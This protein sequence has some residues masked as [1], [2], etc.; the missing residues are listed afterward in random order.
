MPDKPGRLAELEARNAELEAELALYRDAVEHM[1]EGLCVFDAQ[2]RIALSNRRYEEVLRLPKGSVQPGLSSTELIQLGIDAGHYPAGKTAEEILDE[3]RAHYRA[4]PSSAT[5]TRGERTYAIK[6]NVTHNGLAVTTWEDITAQ[7]TA[8]GAVRES[9]GRLRAVLDSMPDCLT[10][11]AESGELIHI[12]PTGLELLQA[13]DIEALSAAGLAFV[14]E[15]HLATVKEV[16]CRVMAGE[17]V[18]WSYD[19]LGLQ[20]RRRHVE[21]HSVPFAMPD[22]SKVHMTITRDISER[23]E[24]HESVRRSEERLRLQQDATGLAGFEASH[25]G[26]IWFTERFA[27]QAG[28]PPGTTE[29]THEEWNAIV[30]P[31]DRGELARSVSES[32]ARGTSFNCEFRIIRPDNGEVRWISSTTKVDKDANGEPLRSVGAHLD[33][34]E[35]KL[36]EEALRESEERFRLAAEA[37]GLGVWDYDLENDRREWSQRLREIFGID[38]DIEP[39][40]AVAEACIHPDDK[41]QFMRTLRDARTNDVSRFEASFRII[42]PSDGVER[43]VTM[44]GWRTH[45]SDDQLR[46]IIM[47]VRDV[48]QEKTAEERVRWSASHDALTRLANRSLFQEK[49]DYAI[50][51]AAGS[52]RAVGLLMLDMDHFKQI[53][54]SLGHDAGDMLL[55]MFAKRLRSVVRHADTVARLGGDEFAV[56]MPEIESEVELLHVARAIQERLREPFIHTGRILDSRVSIGASIYPHHG[57]TP[58]ELMKNA[59]MALYAAKA[60][61]RGMLTMFEPYMREEVQRRSAMVQLAR[62]AIADD[63]I[64]P[65]YQP[66]LDLATRSLVGF[67]ALLRWRM[68]N[69]RIAT[70]SSIEAAFD[71]LNVAAQLSDRMIERIIADMR[72][73]LDRGV[74]FNSVAVNAS[75]A[76]FRRDNFG[77]RV[78]DQLR[79]AGIPT[80]CFQLEVAETVFLGRGAE[81]VHRALA[82]LNMRGVVIALDDFGTGYAS[83]RHLKQF[84]VDKIK[85][86]KGF[87]RDMAVDPGDE[88]IISAV[89]KLGHSLGIKVVAEGIETEEQETRLL[90]LGCEFGQGFLFSRAVSASRVPGLVEKWPQRAIPIRPAHRA[91]RL[92]AKRA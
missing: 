62:D 35:R 7:V 24:V 43:W 21:A 16:H 28:L 67:E 46:R 4:D 31:D 3:I 87:V 65:Y 73:W 50:A 81:Y 34:T 25:G 9:E 40:L 61:G 58:E 8:E 88:A 22:G 11:F 48:T 47:T 13:P 60:A 33:I 54:D 17:A 18:R 71:D 6:R 1:H 91:L 82:L 27:E 14:P 44:N 68:P 12:N 83:L 5:V 59:D 15:E 84:P 74:Q 19:V 89:V 79:R 55:K 90:E 56:V 77:E 78:L 92:L 64:I 2:S 66:K 72:S 70:P 30:H 57:S 36:A 76:E 38:Q 41:P 20:G 80:S 42:R 26:K 86:D 49:L 32:L 63:R 51:K 10:M 45:R 37:A 29:L 69:G 75:A 85:I 39:S 23:E 53:N 52:G